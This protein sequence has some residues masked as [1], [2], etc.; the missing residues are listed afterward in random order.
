MIFKKTVKKISSFPQVSRMKKLVK[1]R[2]LILQVETVNSCNARCVFCAYQKM[3]REK[4]VLPLETFEKIVREYSEMGGG[5][6]LLTPIA[7]DPLLDPYLVKR[8]KILSR[9]ENI[10]QISFT[11][12]GIAF[13]KYSDE[14]ISYIAKKSFMIQFSIGGL[15]ADAYKSLYRVNELDNVLSA[16]S[17]LLEIKKNS[18]SNVV[19]H[20]AFRTNDADFE[21]KH[22]QQI[23]EFREKG[24]YISHVY[25]YMNYGGRIG[26][27][28]LKDTCIIVNGA[29][30]KNTPCVHPLIEVAVCSNGRITCCGCVDIDGD[31]LTI[32]DANMNT[33]S[34]CWNSNERNQIVESFLNKKLCN[35][36][37]KCSAYTSGTS[38]FSSDIFKDI[39]SYKK[40]PLD[41]YLKFMGG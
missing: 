14:D 4:E 8:Y 30:K 10:D 24:V 40:M 22:S 11:T 15:D 34:E 2:P 19:I 35:I 37:K 39:H 7:G 41:F 28:E 1:K 29:F 5:A 16:V 20:L 3:K 33:L 25:M 36:C 9:H 23:E 38:M 27:D 18:D 13:K 21:K 31:Q 6:L 17:R 32:G 26:S 12:N